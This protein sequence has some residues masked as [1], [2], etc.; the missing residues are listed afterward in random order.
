[1]KR[2]LKKTLTLI[3][4]LFLFFS[5]TP[6]SAY[7]QQLEF[8]SK[9]QPALSPPADLTA[10]GAAVIEQNTGKVLYG[11]QENLR[12]Y[13]ASTTKILT[14]LIAAEC[15]DLD[16]IITVGEEINMVPWDSSRACLEIGEQI[17]MRDLIYGLLINSGNDAGNT[18]AVH[19]ARKVSGKNLS[20]EEALK[21]F[22][23]LMNKR[24]KDA[25][26]LNSH[27]MNPHGYHD[28]DHYTTAY[29]LAMIGRAAMNNEFFREATAVTA[30]TNHY[31]STGEPRF[32]QSKNKL[33]NKNDPEYYQWATG[34]KTG[35]TS[36]AGHCLVTFASKD[37]LDL[38]AVVLKS[39]NGMQWS[40]TRQLLEYGFS[41]FV[42]HV[43]VR[44]DEI[45]ETLPV[46]DYASDDW[47]S[48]AVTVSSEDWG[49]VFRKDEVDEIER[50]I[51]WNPEVLSEKAT[52]EMPRVEAPITK[53]QTLGELKIKLHGEVLQSMPLVAVRDVKSKSMLDILPSQPG[54]RRSSI[55]HWAKLAGL[56]ILALVCLRFVI[57]I[58]NRRRR[59]HY[60]IFR[61]Y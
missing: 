6:L 13:P 37:G 43:A 12:L 8:N 39:D 3:L 9:E 49:D 41:N 14:A 25:G 34:G 57:M 46:D 2:L 30:M 44:E 20:I 24:A 16:E 61:R 55:M 23:E 42:Y 58:I 27:F 26:A 19:I 11:K 59:R 60:T 31:W 53:G 28:P 4:I 36:A 32:W 47:G 52:L 15:S 51:M 48:L 38:V 35:Y 10:E 54:G 17:S 22:A 29:D 18:I 56:L 45:I 40:E 7:G 5:Y 50:E 33:L 1:M 21:Y